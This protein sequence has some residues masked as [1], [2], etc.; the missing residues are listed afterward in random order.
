MTH[1]QPSSPQL[2]MSFGHAVGRELVWRQ[3]EA[4]VN[5]WELSAGPTLLGVLEYSGWW[6]DRAELHLA[7]QVWEFYRRGLFKPR[8]E[9]SQ[10][11]RAVQP[12][13]FEPG[14]LWKGTL[15]TLSGET[16]TWG[17]DNV[18]G[19]QWSFMDPGGYPLVAFMAGSGN[20]SLRDF[21]RTQARVRIS[22]SAAPRDDLGMLLG[23]GWYFLILLSQRQ[24]MSRNAAIATVR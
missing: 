12:L 9:I 23:L 18:W 13:F 21:F 8:V 7:D 14:W 10:P 24:S 6:E 19:T 1:Y 15:R 22:A 11:G 2:L 20:F 16:L 4:L 3:P 17:S 5:R